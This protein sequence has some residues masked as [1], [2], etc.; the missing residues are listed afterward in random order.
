[1]RTCFLILCLCTATP[2]V[3]ASLNDNDKNQLLNRIEAIAHK[4]RVP[5]YTVMATQEGRVILDADRPSTSTVNHYLIGSCSKSFT[6]LA[7]LQLAD[8]NLISLDETVRHYLPWFALADTAHSNRVTIR[9]LLNQTSGIPQRYG[10]FDHFTS[11][12]AD[13]ELRLAQ[14][15]SS[16]T[17]ANAPGEA[18]VY[19]NLNYQLLGLVITA[20]TGNTYAAYADQH[21][22]QPIGMQASFAGNGTQPLV[23]GYQYAFAAIPVRS[24]LY[25]HSPFLVPQGLISS[26]AEDMCRYLNCIMNETTTPANGRL[27]SP[28]AYNAL[29]TPVYKGYAMGWT[30]NTSSGKIY[31]SHLGLNED[32]STAMGFCKADQL[33]IVVLSNIN[34][35]E[36]CNEVQQ[37]VFAGIAGHSHTSPRFSPELLKRYFVSGALLFVLL[38]LFYNAHRWRKYGYGITWHLSFVSLLRLIIGVAASF[39]FP[40]LIP[41][42]N[43][44]SLALLISFQPDFGYG[45]IAIAALGSVSA[46]LR[47]WSAGRRNKQL[48]TIQ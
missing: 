44:L 15:C 25:P 28:A 36:F 35:F 46:F 10:Y 14:W 16:I 18:F 47:Y 21:I 13:F 23:P 11:S 29:L 20:V 40:V 45:V 38:G 42:L 1:M 5:N 2:Y 37:T 3:F 41:L 30:S 22:F 39:A 9:H 32:Y 8:K 19:S 6:A 48:R 34:S 4:Y 31:M 17:P 24:P 7:V 12:V 43:N 33:C 27:L 26:T